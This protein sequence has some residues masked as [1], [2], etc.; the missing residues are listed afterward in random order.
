[1]LK[2]QGQIEDFAW[3]NLRVLRPVP[4]HSW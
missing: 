4:T 3:V 1:L 2:R